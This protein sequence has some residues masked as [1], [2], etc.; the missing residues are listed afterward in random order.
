M[1]HQPARQPGLPIT[2]RDTLH[3]GTPL[4]G[5][6][7]TAQT[8][9]GEGVDASLA[10]RAVCSLLTSYSASQFKAG[11]CRLVW[12]HFLLVLAVSSV[13]FAPL[14]AVEIT[15]GTFED[16]PQF[17]IKTESATWFYDRAGGGF[18]RLI[19]RDG[20]DWIAFSKTPLNSFPASAA[21]GY[22]GLPNAV[23]VGPDKGA[24]HPGFDQCAS[25]RAG[26]RQIRTRS[27]SG[28]WQWTWSFAGTTATFHMEQADPEHAWWFLY[29]G[30]VAGRFM[31]REQYWGT[32]A[33][34]PHRDV[35]GPRDQRFGRWQWAYFGDISV[36]RIF[37]AAQHEPDEF[38]DTFWY[39]GSS[40]GGS[41]TAP[42][43]MVVFGFGRG[44]GTRPLFR[45]AGQRFT[46][47]LLEFGVASG[48]DH[49]KAAA[50]IEAALSNRIQDDQ[51]ER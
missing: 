8:P 38:E 23:F 19:D 43:G 41:A 24:G 30:P 20:R 32:N 15:E 26:A 25:E 28:K 40:E 45:G 9:W 5:P 22:R 49:T 16:R 3:E 47:G 31:P 46:V 35:P 33:G 7:P 17:I 10:H 21:A 11:T 42:D 6:L 39:L 36:P 27:H 13:F 29:E 18:S 12:A 50:R 34:G 2:P 48:D 51:S 4:P 1:I 37:F 44:P 14:S